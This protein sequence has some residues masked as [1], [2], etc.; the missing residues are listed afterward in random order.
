MRI[1]R[2]EESCHSFDEHT[3]ELAQVRTKCAELDARI[4]DLVQN[5]QQSETGLPGQ[6]SSSTV[7]VNL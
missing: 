5:V 4:R 7:C 3:R 2:I 1:A 6:L